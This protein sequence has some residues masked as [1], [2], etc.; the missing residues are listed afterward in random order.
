MRETG[1]RVI[2]VV[3]RQNS[4]KTRLVRRMIAHWHREGLRVAAIKH[5]AHAD[6]GDDWEKPGSDT[7]LFA[8]AGA[9]A[10]VVAGGGQSLWRWCED[11]AADDAMALVARMSR[12][13]RERGGIDLIVVEGFKHSP[14]PKVAVLRTPD[15]LAWLRDARLP[16][17]AAVVGPRRA[18]WL[19]GAKWPVYDEDDIPG[20]C[21]EVWMQFALPAGDPGGVGG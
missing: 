13:S 17:L 12:W 5:D 21:R 14:L 16:A 2:S 20:L 19:A 9:V 4:G 15:D 11:P 1:P 10:T 18:A 8:Q 3:G 6:G 7:A